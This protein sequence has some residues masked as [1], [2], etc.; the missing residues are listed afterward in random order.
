MRDGILTEVEKGTRKRATRF[1]FNLPESASAGDAPAPVSAKPVCCGSPSSRLPPAFAP[2]SKSAKPL[3]PRQ[4]STY[5]LVER[6]KAIQDLIKGL[7]HED[8]REAE[9]RKRF[10]QL[11]QELAHTNTLLAGVGPETQADPSRA[12]KSANLLAQ[13]SKLAF[14]G[15]VNITR[16]ALEHL[17]HAPGQLLGQ[18]RLHFAALQPQQ[19]VNP[20]IEIGV[21][22]LKQ[23]AE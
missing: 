22:E 17:V 9:H 18:K 21:I 4:P 19:P 11:K 23:V 16:C 1:R 15:R 13:S 14:R 5:E 6:K 3:A 2:Q 8:F 12:D 10:K 7:P 20:E